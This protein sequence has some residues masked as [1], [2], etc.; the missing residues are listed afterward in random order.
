MRRPGLQVQ[1]L[2]LR[3]ACKNFRGVIW[4]AAAVPELEGVSCVS[5]RGRKF[6]G[7]HFASDFQTDCG[8]AELCER[9]ADRTEWTMHLWR[10]RAIRIWRTTEIV[11]TRNLSHYLHQSPGKRAGLRF[12]DRN[13]SGAEL[14]GDIMFVKCRLVTNGPRIPSGFLLTNRT[15]ERGVELVRFGCGASEGG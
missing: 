4:I 2:V 13:F 9:C 14:R 6:C 8:I 10:Q 3:D 15:D 1:D 7:E 12:G 5:V 11:F